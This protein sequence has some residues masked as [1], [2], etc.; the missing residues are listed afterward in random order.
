MPIQSAVWI[1]LIL[2]TPIGCADD[3]APSVEARPM[4]SEKESLL[5]ISKPADAA[6]PHVQ[7]STL[8]EEVE[9][10]KRDQESL[11]SLLTQTP[12]ETSGPADAHTD[13]AR[14][15]RLQL[16]QLTAE[17]ARWQNRP[18]APVGNE[19]A[20][21]RPCSRALDGEASLECRP[22]RLATGH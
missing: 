11:R 20:E 15:L 17:L 8:A 16:D 9:R 22:L 4:Q 6:E 12:S 2:H 19:K 10:L 18:K 5:L 21:G 1:A 13:S 14:R 7:D 3:P